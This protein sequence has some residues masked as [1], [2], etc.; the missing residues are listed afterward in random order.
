[1]ALP[2]IVSRDEWLTARKALLDEEKAFTQR[3]DALNTS[4]RQLPMIEIDQTSPYDAI[5][6]FALALARTT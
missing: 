1:M 6:I 4:R 5:H 3:R 2:Q